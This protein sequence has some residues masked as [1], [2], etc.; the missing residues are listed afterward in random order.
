M[1]FLP[2]L[3]QAVLGEDPSLLQEMNTQCATLMAT[4]VIQTTW[5][6]LNHPEPRSGR[7]V[8][9]GRGWSWRNTVQADLFKGR[10]MQ[11]LILVK[12]LSK[13]LIIPHLTH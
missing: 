5:L 4:Q 2:R 10:G 13:M 9:Q 8:F 6:T 7:R 1:P 11:G 12:V 3:D